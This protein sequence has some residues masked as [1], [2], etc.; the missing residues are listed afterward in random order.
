[1]PINALSSRGG[2]VFTT[3]PGLRL[4]SWL[5]ICLWLHAVKK[6]RTV[7]SITQIV[8]IQLLFG[9][10]QMSA[11]F[12]CFWV[13]MLLAAFPVDLHAQCRTG[14]GPDFGDGI[15]YCSQPA[16]QSTA[17]SGPQWA[18]R[19]GAIAYGGGGFGAATDMASVAK[20]KKAALRACRDSGGGKNCKVALERSD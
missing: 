10:G 18:M 3:Q 17:P 8:R 20:A 6:P 11:L 12:R 14:S 19:W 13:V 16:P 15:P 9:D 7:K 4:S 5:R 1:M 2:I